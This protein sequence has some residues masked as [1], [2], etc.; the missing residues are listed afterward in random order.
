MRG[1]L[2]PVLI[3]V[4][5]I[6]PVHALVTKHD[7]ISLPW[8]NQTDIQYT[9]PEGEGNLTI[10]CPGCVF[11]QPLNSTF[12]F[13]NF[14]NHSISFSS[15]ITNITNGIYSEDAQLVVNMSEVIENLT[16]I[17]NV[18]VPAAEKRLNFTIIRFTPANDSYIGLFD[19][20]PQYIEVRYIGSIDL[21]KSTFSAVLN[22]T[23]F[24]SYNVTTG[25]GLIRLNF[26]NITN[27][28]K[29]ELT[30]NL[31][32]N[33]DQSNQ[34]YYTFQMRQAQPPKPLLISPAVGEYG[35]D[36]TDLRVTMEDSNYSV[37]Y[38]VYDGLPPVGAVGWKPLTLIEGIFTQ[39]LNFGSEPIGALY[40]K[41]IDRFGN[42][43]IHSTGII[44]SPEFQMAFD[45]RSKGVE[46]G[47]E[48]ALEL[49]FSF[50]PG[51]AK[52]VQCRMQEFK[53]KTSTSGWDIRNTAKLISQD[54]EEEYVYVYADYD[55][56]IRLSATDNRLVRDL[57]LLVPLNINPQEDYSSKLECRYS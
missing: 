57:Q 34:F 13:L 40:L 4:M 45:E 31:F 21:N 3:I 10:I 23:S 2:I 20:I 18:S 14:S 25:P 52:A 9:A 6:L 15:N 50:K 37:Y 12:S 11:T 17:Y 36:V 5:M 53:S 35:A 33:Q 7:I 54:D 27:E 16:F 39:P 51:I 46:P 32:D 30:M 56:P 55:E 1:E 47:D 49:T 38:I 44:S 28:G 22:G 43:R 8:Q 19:E 48:I 42:I 26:L 24:T 29:F 41:I